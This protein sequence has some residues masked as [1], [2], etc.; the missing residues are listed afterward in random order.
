[1]K[2]KKVE[3]LISYLAGLEFKGEHLEAEIRNNIGQGM[4]PFSVRH[5]INYEDEQMFYDFKFRKDHQFDAY[6]LEGYKATH[7]KPIEIEHKV[8]NGIDTGELE[9]RMKKMDWYAHFNN[10]VKSPDN[11]KD[12]KIAKVIS[13]LYELDAHQ[14]IEGIRIQE[15][16]QLKYFPESVLDDWLKDLCSKY[17][18][19]RKFTATDKGFCNAHLA[20]H[21]LSGRL[22][23]LYEKLQPLRLDQ[24]PGIDIYS[25][26][27][28]ILSGNPDSFQLRYNRNEPE[29]YVEYSVPVTKE[30]DAYAADT[31][32][33][34][35]IPYPPIEH[36]VYNG[37][38]SAKLEAMM[39]EVDWHNDREL[40]ILHEDKEPELLPKVSFIQEQ[41]YRLGQDMVGSDIADK[42]QLKYWTDASFFEG[43]IQQTAWDYLETLP[44]RVQQFPVETSAKTAF[45]LLNGRAAMHTSRLSP[46]EK[47]APWIRLDFSHKDENNNYPVKS[48][49]GFIIDD[50]ENRLD[51]LPIDNI[52]YYSNRNALLQ[53]DLL[54]VPIKDGREVILRANPEQKTIDVYTKDMRPIPLNLRLDPDWKPALIQKENVPEKHQKVPSK[55]KPKSTHNIFSKQSK[56]RRRK[57]R[58]I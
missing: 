20:Y 40:F 28:T 18:Q 52:S 48:I 25:K 29:G 36:G 44:K 17:E 14:N 7:R 3:K 24:Y 49:K 27:E 57:G 54:V 55:S 6:K 22:D 13:D 51:L 23:A 19:S 50:L 39:Q 30:Q 38:D 41:M 35:L 58:C 42:L 47:T 1:M 43:I 10:S 33:A 31:Y 5:E 53:G 32:T 15:L 4:S 16:L 21:L 8:I 45:N 26:L 9:E 46:S 12:E 2:G 11:P 56:K 37:I 34:S